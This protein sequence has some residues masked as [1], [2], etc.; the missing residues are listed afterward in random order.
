MED[1]QT[2]CIDS[3]TDSDRTVIF[4]AKQP[5]TRSSTDNSDLF[6]GYTGSEVPK[7]EA[8]LNNRRQLSSLKR[9]FMNNF[10]AIKKASEKLHRLVKTNPQ[11]LSFDTSSAKSG[12]NVPNIYKRWDMDIRKLQS[13]HDQIVTAIQGKRPVTKCVDA[14]LVQIKRQRWCCVCLKPALIWDSNGQSA[15]YFCG[16]DCQLAHIDP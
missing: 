11:L 10:V 5:R 13:Q 16:I 15:T 8:F 1:S 4:N 7:I 3:D 6:P 9:K 2:I 14:L 12:H